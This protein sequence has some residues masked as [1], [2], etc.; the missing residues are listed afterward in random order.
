MSDAYAWFGPH[1]AR[2]DAEYWEDRARYERYEIERYMEGYK[3]ENR[4]M[5]A[6]IEHLS[7]LLSSLVPSPLS[8]QQQPMFL[9]ARSVG[10]PQGVNQ[11]D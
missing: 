6:H 10:T 2:D 1:Q 8:F 5:K 3:D 11:N 9:A 7:R 4:A